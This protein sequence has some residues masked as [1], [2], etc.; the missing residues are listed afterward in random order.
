MDKNTRYSGW[1][2]G[3]TLLAVA[4]TCLVMIVSAVGR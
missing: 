3:A 2:I 4:M 1:I